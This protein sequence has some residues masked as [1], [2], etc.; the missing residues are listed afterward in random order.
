MV[1]CSDSGTKAFLSAKGFPEDGSSLPDRS[2]SAKT[3]I[4]RPDSRVHIVEPKTYKLA[5]QLEELSLPLGKAPKK[6]K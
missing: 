1:K 6:S 2:L 3:V 5:K 4:V